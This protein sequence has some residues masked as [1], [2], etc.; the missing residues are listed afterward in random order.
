[1]ELNMNFICFYSLGILLL[2]QHHYCDELS[3]PS[4]T[5]SSDLET[6]HLTTLISTTIKPQNSSSTTTRNELIQV[7]TSVVKTT[8]T[9]TTRLHRV[10][11]APNDETILDVT[12]PIDGLCL[13]TQFDE[14]FNDNYLIN[15][16]NGDIIITIISHRSN[17]ATEIIKFIINHINGIGLLVHNVTIGVRIVQVGRVENLLDILENEIDYLEHCVDN[18]F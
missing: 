10:T 2:C 5:S 9:H 18:P 1:M 17:N 4:L 16:I 8:T 15:S 6:K 12:T 7:K 13:M 11:N 3:T 14:K